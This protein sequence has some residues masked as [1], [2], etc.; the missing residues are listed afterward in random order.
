[1]Y[2]MDSIYKSVYNNTQSNDYDVIWTHHK[3]VFEYILKY[4]LVDY[5]DK[6]KVEKDKLKV[7]LEKLKKYADEIT[8]YNISLV[9]YRYGGYIS[10]IEGIEGIDDLI[11]KDSD[12]IKTNVIGARDD[13]FSVALRD[14]VLK[15]SIKI[16]DNI[17]KIKTINEGYLKKIDGKLHE[18]EKLK[19]I[20]RSKILLETTQIDN[21]HELDGS[22]RVTTEKSKTGNRITIYVNLLDTM[23]TNLSTMK[24]DFI[25]RYND[26]FNKYN[27]I[28]NEVE[29]HVLEARLEAERLEALRIAEEARLEARLEALRIAEEALRIAVRIAEEARLEAVRRAAAAAV[30]RAAAA[31][32]REEARL[33]AEAGAN[34]AANEAAR[35]AAEEEA[36]AT[37]AEAGAVAAARAAAATANVAAA[38]ARVA[39]EEAANVAEAAAN[40]EANEAARLAAN[41][42][43]R[44]AA[45][46][47]A[48]ARAA[49]RATR[50]VVTRRGKKHKLKLK[51]SP[52]RPHPHPLLL[53]LHHPQTQRKLP[54]KKPTSTEMEEQ[55][56]E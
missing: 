13:G 17:S 3:L 22:V 39:A 30:R 38:A 16:K 41:E 31:A 4:G 44:L 19:K 12:K 20:A 5:I 9:E 27:E 51:R 54:Q 56:R 32:A 8:G 46:A 26:T 33:V 48:R 28:I 43:A 50:R 11:I 6:I 2:N 53:P 21:L 45:A 7:N 40:E 34:E 29:A 25:T 15:L 37:A 14:D 24:Q 1:M 47:A 36:L 23:S 55:G 49:A 52:V 35:L 10:N 18:I 42:A